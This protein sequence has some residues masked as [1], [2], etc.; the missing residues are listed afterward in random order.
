M[1]VKGAVDRPMLAFGAGVILL[2]LCW[3]VSVRAVGDLFIS[4]LAS[5][6]IAFVCITRKGLPDCL[7]TTWARWI[8]FLAAAW[9][10]S[11]VVSD[12][13]HASAPGAALRGWAN[14]TFLLVE[15]IAVGSLIAGRSVRSVAFVLTM[16]V[17]S[18]IHN[19][20]FPSI[21]AA[22]FPWKVVYGGPFTYLA[23]GYAC[24][25]Y[26]KNRM[27][28]PLLLL[29]AGA[30]HLFL[31]LRSEALICGTAG[32]LLWYAASA[33][34]DTRRVLPVSRLVLL[35]GL[36]AAAGFLGQALYVHAAADGTLGRAAQVKYLNQASTG[37]PLILAGR[38]DV[39]VDGR[40]IASSPYIGLGSKPKSD[41]LG[42]YSEYLQ[43]NNFAVDVSRTDPS[44]LTVHS[45]I[46]G[47]WAQAGLL[48]GVF[49]IALLGLIL[50]IARRLPRVAN[51][52][53]APL[54]CFYVASLTWSILFSP[55]S[56]S[57]RFD[58]AFGIVIL[59]GALRVTSEGPAT[60]DLEPPS[61]VGEPKGSML[62]VPR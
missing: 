26:A 9:L 57:N 8:L 47:S 12:L 40:A 52:N 2:P 54:I 45:M 42:L 21:Y 5:L 59:L 3:A 38:G 13:L 49:W 17:A 58:A 53:R 28:A 35:G 20:L 6:A 62:L 7:R 18:L 61:V 36:V 25:V 1:N 41:S 33:S 34:A 4:D 51:D 50:A 22:S 29:L 43:R 11:Q 46:L 56:G 10:G 31:G 27:A 37:A 14:I 16:A 30:L 60:G 24:V 23:V 15:I 48:G 32:L 55:F 44:V 39:L 19:L